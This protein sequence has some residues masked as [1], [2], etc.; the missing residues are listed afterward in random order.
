MCTILILIMMSHRSHGFFFAAEQKHGNPPN[1]KT[2]KQLAYLNT[3]KTT[4]ASVIQL[5]KINVQFPKKGVAKQTSKQPPSKVAKQ[6]PKQPPSKVAKQVQSQ[7]GSKEK[8]AFQFVKHDSDGTFQLMN[9]CDSIE[10][11]RMI[12]LQSGIF[13]EPVLVEKMIQQAIKANRCFVRAGIVE[14]RLYYNQKIESK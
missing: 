14:Y 7:T 10:E 2:L 11:I 13:A 3:Q 8:S 5:L 1:Q 9:Q 6:T 12:L 4:I